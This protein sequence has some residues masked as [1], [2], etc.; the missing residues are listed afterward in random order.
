MSYNRTVLAIPIANRS[1][2]HAKRIGVSTGRRHNNHPTAKFNALSA[3]AT[4]SAV[5]NRF[6]DIP[7]VIRMIT[8][9]VAARI[10]TWKSMNMA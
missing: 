4:P 5:T 6:P 2:N 8:T 9:A 3:T 1:R 10:S 7:L